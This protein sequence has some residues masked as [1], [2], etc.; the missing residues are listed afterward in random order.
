MKEKIDFISIG[1]RWLTEFLCIPI[2]DGRHP[3]DI[4]N[5]STLNYLQEKASQLIDNNKS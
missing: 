1:I 5:V 4:K 3:T 2:I